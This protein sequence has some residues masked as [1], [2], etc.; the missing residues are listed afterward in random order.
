MALAKGLQL[1]MV[2]AGLDALLCSCSSTT[3]GKMTDR[4]DHGPHQGAFSGAA[5]HSQQLDDPSRDEWQHP[6]DVL[7]VLALS[8][9]MSVAD[10][11]AGTGY[12]AV[13]LARALPRGQ[14]IA[15]DVEPDMVRFLEDRARR[16]GLRNVRVTL[17]TQGSSGLAAR[18]V[19]RILV[20]HV[21]H[22]VPD[23]VG[24]L[25]QLAA[26]L[27]PGGKLV[28]VEFEPSASRGPPAG[29]RLAPQRLMV[30][31]AAVGMSTTRSELAPDQYIVEATATGADREAAATE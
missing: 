14:L 25:R 5:R 12:F 26:A 22:H 21:L 29:M 11:G 3:R 7:R 20:V 9:T 16:E 28:V 27:R 4:H 15:T 31:L 30:E 17:A 8:P 1:A 24:L 13:R 6:D 23:R 2:I 19:D 18:S 10:I